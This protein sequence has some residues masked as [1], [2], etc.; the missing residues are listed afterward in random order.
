MLKLLLI[1]VFITAAR[2]QD[3]PAGKGKELV[4]QLCV[5]CHGLE[6]VTSQ[7]ATRR[8]W[9]SILDNMGERGMSGA[10]DEIQTM[11]EYLS[12]NFGKDPGKINVNRATAKELETALELTPK[13]ADAIVKYRQDHGEFKDFA[14]FSQVPEIDAK[15]LTAK[16]DLIAFH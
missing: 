5:G 10:S 6:V 9:A 11:I 12:K 7:R 15:K 4:E 1:L 8:G 3:L 16:K 14:A 13:E 2:S